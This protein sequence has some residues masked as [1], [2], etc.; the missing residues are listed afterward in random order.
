MDL[1]KVFKE[2]ASSG[3]RLSD[4]GDDFLKLFL[5]YEGSR[6]SLNAIDGVL[7]VLGKVLIKAR[8]VLQ[9][10]HG[11]K[12]EAENAIKALGTYE[13]EVVRLYKNTRDQ[14]SGPKF[15]F[16]D[17]LLDCL[18]EA[19]VKNKK[20]TPNAERWV[21]ACRDTTRKVADALLCPQRQTCF[22]TTFKDMGCLFTDSQDVQ[23]TLDEAT[24]N[25]PLRLWL[26]VPWTV[27]ETRRYWALQPQAED[28]PQDSPLK[29]VHK[30][31]EGGTT[32]KKLHKE[33]LSLSGGTLW[34]KL[35]NA[36][37][38]VDS[39]EK[40]GGETYTHLSKEMGPSVDRSF[41]AVLTKTLEAED[42]ETPP[43]EYEG[44]F[45]CLFKEWN[46]Y[47]TLW[48]ETLA[49]ED[50]EANDGIQDELPYDGDEEGPSDA[51]DTRGGNSVHPRTTYYTGYATGPAYRPWTGLR[52]KHYWAPSTHRGYTRASY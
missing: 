30:G 50:D 1:R 21:T 42:E 39:M 13:K 49:P 36:L 32:P 29:L 31:S 24:E 18:T 33:L 5:C 40:Q 26:K 10:T 16:T 51:E 46:A 23:C 37:K 43:T 47:L 45:K 17:Y 27:R 20:N 38:G 2:T 28:G 15:G 12:Q 34:N 7:T 35:T 25:S 41:T 52:P 48:K 11:D 44:L 8:T 14:E 22:K 19:H 6:K 3:N 9:R 4:T